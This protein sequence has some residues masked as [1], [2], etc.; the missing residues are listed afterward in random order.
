M[1]NSDYTD[2]DTG[3]RPVVGELGNGENTGVG[4]AGNQSEG[5]V[6]ETVDLLIDSTLE[7]ME[8]S[9]GDAVEQDREPLLRDLVNLFDERVQAGERESV[10]EEQESEGAGVRL[11]TWRAAR[12]RAV[13]RYE[14]E[15]GRDWQRLDG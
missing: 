12:D 1:G 4:S 6:Q 8:G 9:G 3:R 14:A 5:N 10:S 13:K 2:F 11:R 7:I 15:T